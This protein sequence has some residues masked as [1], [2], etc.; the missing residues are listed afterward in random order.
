MNPSAAGIQT[1]TTLTADVNNNC[2]S[3]VEDALISVPGLGGTNF[4]AALQQAEQVLVV[5]R[6]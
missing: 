1:F 4:E 5:I 6:K 3:D 2:I